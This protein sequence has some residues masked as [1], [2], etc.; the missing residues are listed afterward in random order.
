M[1]IM[2]YACSSDRYKGG[3]HSPSSQS[4]VTPK[5]MADQWNQDSALFSMEVVT[6]SYVWYGQQQTPCGE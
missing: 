4:P 5:L 6:D 2:H 1:H 3:E